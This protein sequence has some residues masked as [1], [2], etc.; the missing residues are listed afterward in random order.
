MNY[1]FLLFA[2][3]IALSS[4]IPTTPSTNYALKCGYTTDETGS[5]S[6]LDGIWAANL[7]PFS[8]EPLGGPDKPKI[9]AFNVTSCKCECKFY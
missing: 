7:D 6:N 2:G 9:K 3:L 5:T 1:L 4:A 8:C